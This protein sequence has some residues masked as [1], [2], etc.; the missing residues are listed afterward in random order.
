MQELKLSGTNKPGYSAPTAP[1]D[2]VELLNAVI[3]TI[4]D[5]VYIKDQDGRYL[6][7]NRAGAAVFGLDPDQVVGKYDYEV[8]PS[9]AIA[10][11]RADDQEIFKS[12]EGKRTEYAIPTR[13]GTRIMDTIKSPY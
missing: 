6:M 12:G 1:Q 3:D 7:M 9:E 2:A 5:A 11:V 10:A 13:T 8:F 4:A